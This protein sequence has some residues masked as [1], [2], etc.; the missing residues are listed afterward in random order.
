MSAAQQYRDTTDC[1]DRARVTIERLI[2]EIDELVSAQLDAILVHPVL[3]DLH[4][5]WLA[6]WSLVDLHLDHRLVLLKIINCQWD[7]L[8][9]ELNRSVDIESSWLYDRVG[10]RELN[11]PGGLP[12]GLLLA[13]Y[14]P[15]SDPG[16]LL[17]HGD[18]LYTLQL[19]AAVGAT[20]LCP[21]VVSVDD[22]FMGSRDDRM[23]ASLQRLERVMAS[24]DF[25]SWQLLRRLGE[26]AFLGVAW[27]MLL[28]HHEQE[29]LCRGFCYRSQDAQSGYLRVGAAWAFVCIVMR[30]F[31]RCRWFG[32][33]R[34]CEPGIEGGGHVSGGTGTASSNLFN[35]AVASIRL[36]EYLENCY[37]GLGFLSPGTTYLSDSLSFHTN[38][39]V[40]QCGSG[41]DEQIH[42]LLQSTLIGCRFAHYLK[43]LV[44]DR[45]GS[46]D[47]VGDCE[48]YLS[49]WLQKYVSD[50][51]YGEDSIMARFPLKH[52][53]VRLEADSRHP[54]RYRCVVYL[55]PQYQYDQMDSEIVLHT[56]LATDAVGGQV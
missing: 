49:R 20:A 56:D 32:F 41:T 14:L 54:G 35:R 34:N 42:G 12:F 22:G 2:A 27:P 52:A 37:H 55:Q 46:F 10:R 23:L 31:D 48:R 38:N 40:M 7:E 21:V 51:D 9:E 45:I 13:D 17:T 18:D 28:Y 1:D 36:G 5:R 6:L 4:G 39:S 24:D 50:V 47:T 3:Q 15:S 16:G 26:S 11:T 25:V 8:A 53:Q 19:L 30:E 44:R 29:R 43:V 33:L